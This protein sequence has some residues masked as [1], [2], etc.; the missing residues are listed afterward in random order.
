MIKKYVFS[1]VAF[2]ASSVAIAQ[3]S[4]TLFGVMDAGV[5]RVSG[6]GAGHR[7][8]LSSGSNAAS[9]LGF[10]GAEEL[11]GG[12]SASFWLEGA[13][14]ADSGTGAG[15]GPFTFQRRASVSLSSKRFG[16]L[17][18]GR[19]FAP[20]W[21]NVALFDPFGARGVASSQAFN[22]FGYNTVYSSNS[23]GYILPT[24]LGGIYGQAQYAFGEKASTSTNSKQG[25]TLSGRLGYANGPLNA[26]V[27]YSVFKQVV[28]ASDAAPITIGRDL[29]LFNVAAS[30]DFGVVKPIVY[31]GQEKAPGN[32]VG[33]ARMDS[34]LLGA[35]APL[36]TG[37][38][39]ATIAHYDMKGSAN[40]FNKFALG[41]GYFF[42]KR[43]QAYATVAKLSNKGAGKRSL[44]VDGL[45]SVGS[46]TAGGHSSGFDLGI[47]HNF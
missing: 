25:N 16:E 35:T 4:V 47:R 33:N 24:G 37:E 41:Y 13:I 46:T 7:I 9:R 10:R 8:G 38:L 2:A 34:F 28:G 20:N 22:N 21:W 29:K 40:D 15:G 43:T 36:G 1:C 45:S 11:G 3:S 42:S 19:D 17:R 6:S 18:L 12:L 31:Y 5:T 14:T 39:R 44:G 27:A 30:W 26:A 32:A 23:I